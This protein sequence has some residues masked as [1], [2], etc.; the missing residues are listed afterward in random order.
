MNDNPTHRAHKEPT[1][2]ENDDIIITDFSKTT[3]VEVDPVKIKQIEAMTI[4][5]ALSQKSIY[6]RFHVG[7]VLSNLSGKKSH[8]GDD[9][10]IL[11]VR[12]T[13]FHERMTLL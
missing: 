6:E 8:G 11:Q 7:G 2:R 4:A 3:K 9:G 10:I 5:D 13:I 12:T 1:A